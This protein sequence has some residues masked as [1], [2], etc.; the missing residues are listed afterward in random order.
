MNQIL[1]ITMLLITILVVLY[2][3]KVAVVVNILDGAAIHWNAAVVYITT[4][5]DRHPFI[6]LFMPFGILLLLATMRIP[7][8]ES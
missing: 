6:L 1:R 5:K 8:A 3:L 4:F 2:I 7:D